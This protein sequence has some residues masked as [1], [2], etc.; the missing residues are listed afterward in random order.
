MSQSI[1][2]RKLEQKAYLTYHQDGLLDLITGTIILCLGVNEAIGSSIWNFIA[3]LLIIVYVPLKRRITFPRLGYV[4]FNVERGGVN[5]LR[6]GAVSMGVLAL[7]LVG[8]LIVLR[9]GNA[10]PLILGVRE[11]PLL[12]YALL[13]FM[14][15]GL[16]GLVIGL[17]RLLVYALLSMLMMIGG[18]LLH[19]PLWAPLLLS[20][21]A[22]VATGAVLL[23][24]F[25]RKYPA[26]EEEKNVIQ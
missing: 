22:I 11:S 7:A 20:G 18:H 6:V 25:L 26:V 5:M 1:D 16:A 10:T 15:F 14:G 23:V 19:L 2:L 8:M 13:G 3:L 17:R 12:L 9:S 24:R 4:K 21:G